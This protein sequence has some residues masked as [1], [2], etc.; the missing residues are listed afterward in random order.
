M[1]QIKGTQEEARKDEPL[2]RLIC[3]VLDNYKDVPT[4]ELFQELQVT[5]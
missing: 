3:E 2:Q 1:E 5:R 4:N